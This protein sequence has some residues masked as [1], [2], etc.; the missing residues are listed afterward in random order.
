[1]HLLGD[2][3]IITLC[4]LILLSFIAGL[5][6]AVVGG[7]GLIQ[8]PALLIG[9]PTTPLP[10]IFGTNK[11]ASLSGTLI[12]AVQYGKRIKFNL[13]L[14]IVIAV[15]AGV[16]SYI[17]AQLVTCINV[18]ILKPV[19]LI[20][21]I[22]IAIYT[23]FKKDLGSITSKQLPL[24][25]QILRGIFIGIIIGF[26]DGL[27]GPGTGSFFVLGFVMVL[28]FDFLH[29]SA[30]AKIVNC[31]TNLSALVV[32][33]KQGN[34]ILMLAII[35]AVCNIVGN[36]IGAKLALKRGNSFIRTFFLIV[37]SLLISRYAYDI[38]IAV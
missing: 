5:I 7:G 9:L 15:F 4:S 32:F 24:P 1:V 16:A 38:F 36:I 8:M 28:G 2:I 11:I 6:D 21:L 17:G 12:A 31:M 18:N 10:T 37:V 19:I 33:I 13:I 29:A 27:L 14:L 23:Y 30:Y 35:M 26:Y 20:A 3:S 22:G 25:Q 34:Y